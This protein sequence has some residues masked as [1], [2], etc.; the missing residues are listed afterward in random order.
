MTHLRGSAL[1]SLLLATCQPQPDTTTGSTG[2]ASTST[3]ATSTGGTG[4]VLTSS[5]TGTTGAGSTTG[6]EVTCDPP[7][8]P[9]ALA[10]FP[11]ALA[12]AVCAQKEACGCEVDFACEGTWAGLAEQLVAVGL[13]QGA[14]YDG[15]CAAAAL[16]NY[17]EAQ[18]CNLKSMRPTALPCEDCPVFHGSLPEGAT[19]ENTFA[20]Y[21]DLLQPCAGEALCLE[22]CQVLGPLEL[23]APCFVDNVNLGLCPPQSLCDVLGSATC[24]PWVSEGE[25]CT[26]VGVCD[27]RTLFCN[28][29]G[30]CELRRPEGASCQSPPECASI[31]CKGG[32]CI[33][34]VRI[35]DATTLGGLR[36]F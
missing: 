27:P 20:D 11:V 25:D 14:T 13:A 31:Q 12:T 30:V 22:G 29:Q 28:A 35:C 18:G 36:P 6:D 23:G 16:I 33:D 32:Q 3:S 17:I 10:D 4:E 8:A 1:L 7:P 19:C 5:A 34:F 21:G 9:I 26:G 2:A 15:T 24:E